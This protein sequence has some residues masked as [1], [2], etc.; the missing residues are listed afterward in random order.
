MSTNRT[1]L[2]LEDTTIT[3]LTQRS[4]RMAT[5]SPNLQVRVE[6]GLWHAALTA[7]LRRIPLTVAEASC[8][9]DVLNG[10]MLTPGIGALTWMEVEDAFGFARDTDLPDPNAS[11]YAAKWGVDEE[12]LLTRLR[13]LGPAADHALRDAIARWWESD[14]E[15]TVEG[16]QAVGITIV[17]GPR[18]VTGDK[19]S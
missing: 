17:A 3:W 18:D 5:G 15:A 9:A 14:G 6:L 1:V 10:A 11:S 19:R 16:F 12:S 13:R 7:E 8:L 2:R 4:E